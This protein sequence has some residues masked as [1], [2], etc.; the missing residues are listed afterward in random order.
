[1]VLGVPGK[2]GGL[3]FSGS[4][5]SVEVYVARVA[6][7]IVRFASTY[8]H[9]SDVMIERY[10]KSYLTATHDNYSELY[11]MLVKGDFVRPRNSF[12]RT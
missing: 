5:L 10:I 7:T 1:M 12:S 11:I 6:R 9:F 8:L 3:V 4:R 2:S